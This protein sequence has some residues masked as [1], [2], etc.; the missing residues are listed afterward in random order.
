MKP[1][2]TINNDTSNTGGG[3]ICIRICVCDCTWD[4][5]CTSMGTRIYTLNNAITLALDVL[6]YMR[7]SSN[8][9]RA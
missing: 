3:C 1:T 6:R 2:P 9:K 8:P 7:T 4:C 5:M